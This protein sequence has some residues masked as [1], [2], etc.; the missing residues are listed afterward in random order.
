MNKI[1]IK[2]HQLGQI[3]KKRMSLRNVITTLY[4]AHFLPERE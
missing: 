4:L 2:I 3:G 1:L